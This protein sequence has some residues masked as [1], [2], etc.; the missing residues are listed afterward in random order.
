MP[1]S[2]PQRHVLAMLLEGDE[3]AESV[4]ARIETGEL[5]AQLASDSSL[6]DYSKGKQGDLGWH[7]QDVLAELLSSSAPGDFAFGAQIGELSQP[8][9]DADKTKSV[10]YWLI[11]VIE[12]RSDPSDQ[13]HL[14]V[15]LL[16]SEQEAKQMRA[17]L[18]AGE[19]FATLAKELSQHKGSKDDG[20]VFEWLSV[21]TLKTD[22]TFAAWTDAVN[23]EVGQLSEPLRDFSET[24]TGGYWLVRLLE[25]EDSRDISDDD[26]TLLAAK[27]TD[28]WIT[29]L[30]ENPDNK[31]E[32]LLTDELKEW[33]VK[34]AMGGSFSL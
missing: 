5:F 10:G 28:E 25:K 1:T 26:R 3:Q 33:A 7:P 29:A 9:Y 14:Q 6:D 15:T 2:A 13:I 21:E 31:L 11:K 20:G 8:L 34:Q 19:D 12:K 23:M 24:T 32:N 22:T 27:A 30:Q 18:V 16:G 4:R 17:R